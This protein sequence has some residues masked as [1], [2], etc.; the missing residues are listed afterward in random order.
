MDIKTLFCEPFGGFMSTS[1]VARITESDIFRKWVIE[2]IIKK[3]ANEY[4]NQNR[5]RIID[6]IDIDEI[7]KGVIPIISEEIGMAIKNKRKV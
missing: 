4:V 1:M 3:I 6:S 5:K 7:V 2:R